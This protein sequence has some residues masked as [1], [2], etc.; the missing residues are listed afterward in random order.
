MSAPLPWRKLRDISKKYNKV[1]QLRDLSITYVNADTGE[2]LTVGGDWDRVA[3]KYSKI[4]ST[5]KRV[6]RLGISQ[7][8]M[9]QHSVDALYNPQ[10]LAQEKPPVT[11]IIVH[12]PRRGGKSYGLAA[13]LSMVLLAKPKSN[14]WLVGLRKKH[15]ENIIQ[16]IRAYLHPDNYEYDRHNSVLRLINGSQLSARSERNYNADRG[17]SLDV[18]ALDEAAFMDEA[19]Y[20]AGIPAILDRAGFAILASSPNM[21][22]YFYRLAERADSNDPI[23][24]EVVKAVHLRPEHNVFVPYLDKIRKY[25]KYTMSTDAYQQEAEGKFIQR[26]GRVMPQFEKKIHV[27]SRVN[28]DDYTAQAVEIAFKSVGKRD[29]VV[30]VDYNVNPTAGVICKFDKHGRVWYIAEVCTGAGTE[31]WGELLETR[32]MELGAVDPHQQTLIIGDASGEYQDPRSG[33]HQSAKMLRQQGWTVYSPKVRKRIN[34]SVSTRM[35]VMRS[36]HYNAAGEVRMYVDPECEMLIQSLNELPLNAQ[37][38]P[39]KGNNLNHIY[40]AASYPVYRFWG[41]GASVDIWKTQLVL[42]PRSRRDE[43]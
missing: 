6:F 41:T 19:V 9:I 27:L 28:C 29:F 33:S 30:G 16:T 4:A 22:N 3:G 14:C 18:Y 26:Q 20:E 11:T 17:N 8:E 1:M 21:L 39:D 7:W 23:A 43:E 35:E 37:G 25:L 36:L 38:K 24:T 2:A 32:L 13:V 34:P 42:A 40:D 5:S 10:K 15:G 12:A 31:I